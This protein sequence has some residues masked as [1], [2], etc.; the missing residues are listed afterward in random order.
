[1]SQFGPNREG[2][3]QCR[4]PR[5]SAPRAAAFLPRADNALSRPRGS[6]SATAGP[7]PS[8]P[9]LH[10]YKHEGSGSSLGRI[11]KGYNYVWDYRRHGVL[12]HLFR[13]IEKVETRLKRL[14]RC[15]WFA[16]LLMGILTHE[17]LILNKKVAA[18]KG[19]PKVAALKGEPSA[20]ELGLCLF[21]PR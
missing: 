21:F 9:G 4:R 8:A 15:Q 16:F 12:G 11:K 1:M 6:G 10:G 5:P 3:Q 13:R 20:H 17:V 18:L 14:R 19:E 7:R 2:A